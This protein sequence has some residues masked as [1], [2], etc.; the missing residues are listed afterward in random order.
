MV[1]SGWLLCSVR[2]FIY[3]LIT[4]SPLRQSVNMCASSLG[5][6]SL[7]VLRVTCIAINFALKM[8]CRPSSLIASSIF[9]N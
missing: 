6:S 4:Y 8:F 7:I 5:Y 9:L 1:L 3:V 2:C